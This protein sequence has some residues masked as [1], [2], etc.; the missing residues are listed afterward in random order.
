MGKEKPL[1]A[2][3]PSPK[4][5]ILANSPNIQKISSMSFVICVFFF[6]YFNSFAV[7][8][9]GIYR[10]NRLKQYFSSRSELVGGANTWNLFYRIVM[11]VPIPFIAP[12]FIKNQRKKHYFWLSYIGL[13]SLK[14]NKKFKPGILAQFL[15]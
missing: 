1:P 10:T 14:H 15:V 8:L 9:F 13:K 5:I 2:F 4:T 3:Y 6:V 7:D 12:N 11:E